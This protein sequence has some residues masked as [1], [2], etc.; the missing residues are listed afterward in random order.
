MKNEQFLSLL[1]RLNDKAV[2][3]KDLEISHLYIHG[4][5]GSVDEDGM[6]MF[7]AGDFFIKNPMETSSFYASSIY[8][9]SKLTLTDSRE[10]Y[11]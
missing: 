5:Y 9:A 11:A 1:E 8:K 7:D 6:L 2:T 4:L 10:L 3:G